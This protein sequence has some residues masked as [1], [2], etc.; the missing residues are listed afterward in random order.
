MNSLVVG[1]F[2]STHIHH[3]RD[4]NRQIIHICTCCTWSHAIRIRRPTAQTYYVLLIKLKLLL[5]NSIEILIQKKRSF[6]KIGFLAL[7]ESTWFCLFVYFFCFLFM[8]SSNSSMFSR[9]HSTIYLW[10]C[11]NMEHA[12]LPAAEYLNETFFNRI[13]STSFPV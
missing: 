7:F 5:Y 6:S 3:L 2:G 8:V 1:W 13:S 10:N 4:F 11:L 12:N 9:S